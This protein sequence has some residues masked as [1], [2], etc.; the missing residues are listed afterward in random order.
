MSS[1]QYELPKNVFRTPRSRFAK[2][3]KQETMK[4]III[5]ITLALA[6]PFI[7][8]QTTTTTEKTV[9]TTTTGT[10]TIT[11]YEP[12]KT[13][14]LKESAGPKTYRFGKKV[15]YVTKSGKTIPEPEL[16]TRIKV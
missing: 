6:A 7:W 12:G 13:I 2:T 11:E 10:G 16:K 9:T 14:I 4:H 1:A 8:A 5:S 3:I 15:V